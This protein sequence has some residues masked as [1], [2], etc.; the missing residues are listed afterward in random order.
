MIVFAAGDFE[1]M[2]EQPEIDPAQINGK[3]D[4]G[5][6]QPEHDKGKAADIEKQYR[7]QRIDKR[8]ETRFEHSLTPCFSYSDYDIKL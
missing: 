2:T 1:R 6:N 4:G 7:R 8:L 5:D 3:K